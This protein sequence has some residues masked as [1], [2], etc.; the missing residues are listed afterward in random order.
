MGDP[1]DFSGK[2]V[3][4]TGGTRGVGLET[5][6]AFG[7]RGARVVL[8]FR[9]GDHDEAAILRR[10]ADAGA[11]PPRIVMADVANRDDTRALLG[12]IAADAGSLDVLVSNV[13]SAA[14]VRSFEDYTLKGL[15]QSIS[16]SSWPLVAYL[17]EARA[18]LGRY[19]GHVVA[20]SSTGP[21][22]FAAGYDFVAAAKTVLEVFVRYLNVHL[23][24]DG[25]VI[26]AVCA[27][28]I[29]TESFERT[30]GPEFAAFVTRFVPDSYWIE[31]AQ[32]ADAIVALCSGYCDAIGGQV[33]DVDKG[34][35]FFSNLMGLYAS[36][37]RPSP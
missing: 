13:S 18:V 31:P 20:L 33:V 2:T 11:P 26:N 34:T 25:V 28:G 24:A 23:R 35:T 9:W 8:T 1:F 15:K 14:V 27:G 22:H 17:Q 6:L 12:G 3:L 19:P 29:R 21:H 4:V 16:Y 5:G 10:F 36:S 7:R 37:R 30:F 32:V